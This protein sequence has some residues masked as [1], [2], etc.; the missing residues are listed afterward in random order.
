MKLKE[1]PRGRMSIYHNT[2]DCGK[3][4]VIR[5]QSSNFPEY[6]TEVYVLCDCGDYVEFE[7]PVN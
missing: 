4:H 1:L 3:Q 7:L 6:E 5:T 2:C